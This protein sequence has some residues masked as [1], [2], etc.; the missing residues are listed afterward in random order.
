MPHYNTYSK[1]LKAVG[2]SKSHN[3]RVTYSKDLLQ[4]K[5]EQGKEYKDVLKEV[6]KEIN[7]HRPQMTEYYLARS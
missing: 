5:L 7:H 3:F 2:I 4:H 1:D 6:S